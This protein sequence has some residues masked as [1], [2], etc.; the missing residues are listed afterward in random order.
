MKKYSDIENFKC[1]S[2]GKLP[3]SDKLKELHYRINQIIYNN[4]KTPIHPTIT[5]T[6]ENE[7]IAIGVELSYI[8]DY[9]CREKKQKLIDACRSIILDLRHFSCDLS[10]A[11]IEEIESTIQR[12]KVSM[13]IQVK[14]KLTEEIAL[15]M[16][17]ENRR[18]ADMFTTIIPNFK[19]MQQELLQWLNGRF[20]I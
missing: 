9:R 8:N 13:Y 6:L 15:K 19:V 20:V 12:Y 17:K 7:L 18:L 16:I 10:D 1:V 11:D 4:S 5:K 3:S 14:G 2:C